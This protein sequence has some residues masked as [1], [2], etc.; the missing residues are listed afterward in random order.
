MGPLSKAILLKSGGAGISK[1]AIASLHRGE[2]LWP[3]PAATWFYKESL[4]GP[5]THPLTHT[6]SRLLLH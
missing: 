6:L 3:N 2:A 4:T 1:T 5:Q